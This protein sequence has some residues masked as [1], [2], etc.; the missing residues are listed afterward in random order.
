M[1]ERNLDMVL[2]F[3]SIFREHVTIF[4]VFCVQ[5]VG[6]RK[7]VKTALAPFFSLFRHPWTLK[8]KTNGHLFPKNRKQTKAP[9]QDFFFHLCL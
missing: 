3:F 5:G 9:C 7:R 4:F 8:T 1:K 2:W 6:E